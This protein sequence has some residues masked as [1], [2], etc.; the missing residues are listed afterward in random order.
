MIALRTIFLA[1]GGAAALLLAFAIPADAQMMVHRGI[2]PWTGMPYR[3]V[4][5]RNP[6]TGRVRTSTRFVDPWTGRTHR[7]TQMYN[8]WTGHLRWDAPRRG[9]W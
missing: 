9:W 1:T 7:T 6:W 2:N 5:V 3:N 8:P 4:T